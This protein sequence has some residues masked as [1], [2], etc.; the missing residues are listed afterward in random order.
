[1]DEQAFKAAREAEGYNEF[2]VREWEA[3]KVVDD[4]T[5]D[6]SAAVLVLDG[7]ITIDCGD[8]P[9]TYRSGDS[10]AVA[11]GTVHNEAVGPAG[12]SFLVARK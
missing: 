10:C 3:G 6:F 2:V 12:V 7:E 8:G 4:H 11:A 5:H 9:T 1:M